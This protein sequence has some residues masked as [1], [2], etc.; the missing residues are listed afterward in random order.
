MSKM[1]RIQTTK[2]LLVL[3]ESYLFRYLPSNVLSEALQR[4]KGI[5]RHEA[6]ERRAER[7]GLKPMEEELLDNH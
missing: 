6:A 4:G 2:C 5:K 1:I 7:E 3:P